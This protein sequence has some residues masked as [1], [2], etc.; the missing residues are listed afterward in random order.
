M[1]KAEFKI[2]QMR[3][4]VLQKEQGSS[5]CA[6]DSATPGSSP[7]RLSPAESAG[8]RIGGARRGRRAGN[9]GRAVPAGKPAEVPATT[10][11]TETREVRALPKER[12]RGPARPALSASSPPAAAIGRRADL[13]APRRASGSSRPARR[14]TAPLPPASRS[15]QSPQRRGTAPH[16]C[17]RLAGGAACMAGGPA[18][19]VRGKTPERRDQAQ[20]GGA[21]RRPSPRRG[22]RRRH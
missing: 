19:R 11:R 18:S 9:P 7:A 10:D 3:S 5:P 21:G 6:L 17:R 12:R 16:A 4:S 20:D 1:Q 2:I 22:R 13:P 14:A 15:S 8:E